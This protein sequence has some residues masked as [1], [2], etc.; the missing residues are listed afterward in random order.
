MKPL[1]L[2]AVQAGE[3]VCGDCTRIFEIGDKVTIINEEG[4]YGRREFA[5]C[6]DCMK[7]GRWDHWIAEHPASATL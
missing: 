1:S 7:S 4:N 6:E 5:V 3:K 2:A